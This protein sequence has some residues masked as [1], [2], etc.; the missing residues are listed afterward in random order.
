MLG[1][2]GDSESFIVALRETCSWGGEAQELILKM[3]MNRYRCGIIIA[4]IAEGNQHNR[5]GGNDIGVHPCGSRQTNN[6]PSRTA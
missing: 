5:A 3:Q 4:I 1:F 2:G 6:T